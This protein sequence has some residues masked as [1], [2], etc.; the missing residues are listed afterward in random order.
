MPKPYAKEF[1]KDVVRLA[2]NREP[3]VTLEQIAAD[4]GVHPPESRIAIVTWIERI[5]HRRRR[6]R[7]LTRSPTTSATLTSQSGTS[8]SPYEGT[9]RLFG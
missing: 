7:R 2:R 6:Q 8:A 5:Y 3:G 1:R 4:F 9:K